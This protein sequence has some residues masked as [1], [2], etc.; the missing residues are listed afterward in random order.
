MQALPSRDPHPTLRRKRF[1]T[2]VAR[3]LDSAG[4]SLSSKSCPRRTNMAKAPH[5]CSKS[6]TCGCSWEVGSI[7]F[8]LEAHVGHQRTFKPGS[9]WVPADNLLTTI[10][11]ERYRSWLQL[12]KDGNQNMVRVWGGGVYEPDVFYDICDGAGRFPAIISLSLLMRFL[13]RAWHTRL[14]GLSVCLWSVPC[15]WLFHEAGQGRG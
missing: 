5:S 6:T 12:L 9:N 14:A 3:K 10:T 15:T 11:P 13:D 1:S 4:S 8:A 7:S 2:S